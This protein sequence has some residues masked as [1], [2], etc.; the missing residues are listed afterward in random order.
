MEDNDHGGEYTLFEQNNPE[1]K[2][3]LHCSKDGIIVV[4]FNW[5]HDGTSPVEIYGIEYLG[6]LMGENEEFPSNAEK[7]LSFLAEGFD[8]LDYDL[9]TWLSGKELIISEE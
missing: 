4:D 7:E 2:F 6:R 3:E 9:R 1:C 5:N 8:G